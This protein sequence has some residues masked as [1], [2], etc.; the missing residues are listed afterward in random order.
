[1]HVLPCMYIF[2]MKFNGPKSRLVVLGSRQVQ[3]RDFDETFAPVVKYSSIRLLLAIFAARYLELHQMEVVTAFLH[4][5][6]DK[7]I[8][9]FPPAG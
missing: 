7:T 1:M 9:M 4:G 3:G 8:F 2:R 5:T 6:L